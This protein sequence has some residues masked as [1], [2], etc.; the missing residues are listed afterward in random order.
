MNTRT[1]K[2]EITVDERQAIGTLVLDDGRHVVASVSSG[3]FEASSDVREAFGLL[4]HKVVQ[5]LVAAAV[6]DGSLTLSAIKVDTP[7]GM[8]PMN[9]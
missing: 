1:I 9:G 6:P 3:A 5:A 8:P 2:L 4:C 7:G